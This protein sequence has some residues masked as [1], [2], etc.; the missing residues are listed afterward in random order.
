M[1]DI[2]DIFF[3][4]I[5][6]RQYKAVLLS[7][8]DGVLSGIEE[9]VKTA[10]E[11]GLK[12]ESACTEGSILYEG[13]PF[14]ELTGTPKQIAM[15]EERIIG[16]LAKTSGIATAARNATEIAS[17]R[18]EIVS[19]SW[20][21]MPPCMKTMVRQAIL[22]GGAS[23]RICEPPMLYMDKNFVKMF[24]SVKAALDA[25]AEIEGVTKIIQI[26]GKQASV[27]EET[28]EAIEGGAGILMVDTGEITDAEACIRRLYE[29]NARKNVRVAFAGNVKLSDIPAMADRGIDILCIGKEIV[30]ALLLD[31]KLNVVGEVKK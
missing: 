17:G 10:E 3:R 27:E 9:A 22:T 11:L 5:S 24:G 8:R 20:K 28:K 16:T 15:A 6:E 30:D 23:F 21:K 4:S 18:I 25:A 29:M 13:R 2:R 1:Q 12:W 26:R 31:M 14:A 19:G 7:E